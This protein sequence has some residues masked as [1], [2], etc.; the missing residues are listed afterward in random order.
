MKI[1]RESS[2]TKGWFIGKFEPS[3]LKTQVFEASVKRYN[4][5]DRENKHVHKIA[6][7]YTIVGSGEYL[8]NNKK[9]VSGDIVVVNP[10]EPVEF[11]CLSSGVTFVIKTPSVQGDKYQTNE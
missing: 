6:T 11:V 5:G 4:K 8:M 3:L 7:E 9:I 10:G 2:F 1:F